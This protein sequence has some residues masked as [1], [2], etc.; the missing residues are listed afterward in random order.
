MSL[1]T[2]LIVCERHR[3]TAL[4]RHRAGAGGGAV[5]RPTLRVGG[6]ETH[7]QMADI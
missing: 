5:T 4:L 2:A 3:R 1:R 7:P 6:D